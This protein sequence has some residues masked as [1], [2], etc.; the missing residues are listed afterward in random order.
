M[1]RISLSTPEHESTSRWPGRCTKLLLSALFI[2]GACT[3]KTPDQEPNPPDGGVDEVSSAS[4]RATGGRRGGSI[5][6]RTGEGDGGGTVLAGYFAL[7]HRWQLSDLRYG[8][9]HSH[10]NYSIDAATCGAVPGQSTGDPTDAYEY[11]DETTDLD[12]VGLSDHAEFRN[13]L[14]RPWRHRRDGLSIWQSEIALGMEANDESLLRDNDVLFVFADWEYTNTPGFTYC[15]SDAGYGHKN[16]IFRDL[17]PDLLPEQRFGACLLDEEHL[18]ED[19]WELFDAL[20]D[21]RPSCEGCE[22]SALTI[23]HTPAM[24]GDPEAPDN[25]Q[26]HST[27]WDAVDPDFVRHV[28]IMSKWGSSEGHAPSAAGCMDSDRPHDHPTGDVDEDLSVRSTLLR[29]WID[30][31]DAR[32]QLGFVGGT[33]NHLGRPGNDEPE[34]CGM[35]YRGA[36]TGIVVPDLDRA[37]LWSNLWN[38][39]TIAL[40]TGSRIRLLAAVETGGRHLPM[41]DLGPHD[42][43]IRVR[44]LASS[45]VSELH[46]IVDGCLERVIDGNTLDETLSIDVDE[47]HYVY[48]RAV[49][50]RSEE[51]HRYA[52]S[53]P[54]YLGEP[55]E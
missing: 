55:E 25:A 3:G 8:E 31:G 51:D 16:V 4:V 6:D 1:T 20:D 45:E 40:S 50:V 33:D 46:L 27:D 23:I 18:A 54:I 37:G 7:R 44:A 26:N 35:G 5:G 14:A 9:F 43:T 12:F 13:P 47:R 52:W 39:R 36:I 42:G 48:V 11:A 17:D 32:Y 38:R 10:S 2:L 21:Y 28:E 34:Q 49:E 19:A 24:V 15:H 41:G 53:S 29:R 30:E 22:G